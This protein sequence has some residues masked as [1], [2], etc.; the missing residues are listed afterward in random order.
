[1]M[2][3]AMTTVSREQ[4]LGKIM[5]LRS[6]K[7]MAKEIAREF[8]PSRVILF[9]SHASGTARP[10]SDVD[11]LV[12]FRTKPRPDTSLRIR[13]RVQRGFAMDVIVMDEAR[14]AKRLALGDFFLMDVTESGKVL[15]E[16]A[17]P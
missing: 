8:S 13:R 6:I 5:P 7:E 2:T 12:L 1:M 3:G 10:D 11:L 14:L 17:H 9:G 15:Y 4:H 16:S